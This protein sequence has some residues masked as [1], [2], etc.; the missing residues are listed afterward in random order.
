MS[1]D[2]LPHFISFLQQLS[3]VWR[4]WAIDSSDGL[5]CTNM[6]LEYPIRVALCFNTTCYIERQCWFYI[7]TLS[8]MLMGWV[9]VPDPSPLQ[10]LGSFS[11][12]RIIPS[13]EDHCKD[14]ASDPKVLNKYLLTLS[15]IP[16]HVG[17]EYGFLRIDLQITRRKISWGKKQFISVYLS[18]RCTQD[19]LN[20]S[21]HLALDLITRYVERYLLAL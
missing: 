1:S 9:T 11:K 17:H 20:C 14:W 7:R 19:K 13:P 3:E 8:I 2:L 15:F 21:S 18:E 10:T 16:F 6:E 4:F 5:G 12:M